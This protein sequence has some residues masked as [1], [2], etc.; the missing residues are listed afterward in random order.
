MKTGLAR[1]QLYRSF[2]QD[3]NCILKTTLAAVKA[4]GLELRAK[5]HAPK[6]K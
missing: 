3:G 5:P 6:A 4:L 1:E 2:S